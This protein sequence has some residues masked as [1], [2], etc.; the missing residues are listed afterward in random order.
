MQVSDYL[1][2]LPD[3]IEEGT[4]ETQTDP[5]IEVHEPA[6]YREPPQGVEKET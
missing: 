4:H 2:A 5:M 3:K 6:P 1:E